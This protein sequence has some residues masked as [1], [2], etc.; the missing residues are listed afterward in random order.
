MSISIDW[1]RECKSTMILYRAKL[2]HRIACSA[3]L[4]AVAVCLSASTA[5][6]DDEE[7]E[8]AV[9]VEG[10]PGPDDPQMQILARYA[11][12]NCA[13]A[14]RV[15]KLSD[16][17]EQQLADLNDAWLK[18]ECE[19]LLRAP[20]EGAAAGF[21]RMFGLGGLAPVR[22]DAQPQQIIGMVS[23][24]IDKKIKSCLNIDQASAFNDE[25]D[26]RLKFRRESHAEVIVGILDKR[27][28]LTDDQRIELKAAISGSLNK[29]VA[30]SIYLMNEN[31]LPT[32]SRPAIAKVL[33]KE[34]L[35]ALSQWRNADFESFQFEQQVMG[36]QEQFVIEK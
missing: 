13:L 36:Q 4:I 34:Q 1:K 18:A 16:E 29:D 21:A 19:K 5:K 8:A 2:N 31:Y 20:K 26:A 7:F 17:Q 11:R 27:L 28:F 6:C 25:L 30:W 35:A 10:V 9:A 3:L 33:D 22:P 23:Q 24:E 14:R 32:L 12:V 15:C